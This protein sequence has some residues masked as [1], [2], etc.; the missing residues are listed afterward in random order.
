VV[1][2]LRVATGEALVAESNEHLASLQILH[3]A[4]SLARCEE[5]CE[6]FQAHLVIILD[7]ASLRIA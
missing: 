2:N 4:A 7:C 1:D 6:Y 5:I 3:H